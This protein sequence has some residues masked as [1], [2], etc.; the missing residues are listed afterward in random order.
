MISTSVKSAYKQ[1]FRD[2]APFILVIVP[3]SMLFG[4]LAT[5]AGLSIFET[6]SFSVVVIAG[7]AQ[8]T[9]LQLMG[10]DAPTLGCAG[11]RAGG[12]LAHGD[13]F[14]LPEPAYWWRAALA[15]RDCGL[16][17]G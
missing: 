10:E 16:L 5:E 2:G 14:G 4:V 9:A 3:F 13:V 8:F 6:L 7:A 11:L 15:T 1:G 12:E 17:H